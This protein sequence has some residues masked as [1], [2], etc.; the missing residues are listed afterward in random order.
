VL[1]Q[2]SALQTATRHVSLIS[3]P[4][5]EMKMYVPSWTRGMTFAAVSMP[6]TAPS[7]M[8]RFTPAK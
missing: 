4:E 2:D 6:L 8:A 5:N 3:Q 1:N 7:V